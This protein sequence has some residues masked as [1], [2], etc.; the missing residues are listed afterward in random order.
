MLENAA[1]VAVLSFGTLVLAYLT[2]GRFVASRIFRLDA[3]L[4]TPSH[5]L[6]DGIDFVPTRVRPSSS[7][8]T[9]RPSPAWG[10]SW[11]RRLPSSGAGC[12]PSSG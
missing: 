3:N 4:V 7:A 9:S 12:P 1:L 5:E 2:Y 11:D 10:R 8:T 6:E